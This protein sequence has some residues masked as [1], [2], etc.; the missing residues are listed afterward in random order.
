MDRKPGDC[1]EQDRY[2]GEEPHPFPLDVLFPDKPIVFWFEEEPMEEEKHEEHPTADEEDGGG[3]GDNS[4]N[5]G[6]IAERR[7]E[8]PDRPELRRTEPKDKPG[9]QPTHDKDRDEQPPEQE[10]PSGPLRHLREHFCVDDGVIYAQDNLEEAKT[11]NG[12]DGGEEL[13]G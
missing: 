9:Q 4:S 10:P 2:H 1:G 3:R 11:E 6:I 12:E 13:H 7:H 8:C 5:C